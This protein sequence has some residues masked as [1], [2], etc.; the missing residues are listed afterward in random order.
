MGDVG[1]HLGGAVVFQGLGGFAQGAGGI[2]H[3]VHQYAGAAFHFTDDMHHLG[4]IGLGAALVDDG[5]VGVIELLG[6]GAG[7]D[8]TAHVRGDHHQVVMVLAFDVRHDQRGGVDVVYRDIEEALNLVGVKIHGN[9]AINTNG[10]DHVGDHFGGNRHT[11]GAHAA[12]LAG[13]TKVGDNSGDAACGGATQG[14]GHDQQFHQV[15]VGRVAGGLHDK[16]VFAAHVFLDFHGNFA[17]AERAHIGIADRQVQVV[18]HGFGQFGICVTG[19]NDELGHWRPLGSCVVNLGTA[20]GKG[21]RFLRRKWLGY[22]DSNLGIT[23]SKPAALPT[24]LY[25]NTRSQA[26]LSG[27][28]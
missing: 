28:A 15:V 26:R 25:P 20:K 3:V 19:E 4:H 14:V 24:W 21:K 11:G 23:G 8:Y 16:D 18:D 27:F 12:I 6:Q 5:Q 13:I 7:T 10:G 17:I 9:H 1:N 2:D 22:Q